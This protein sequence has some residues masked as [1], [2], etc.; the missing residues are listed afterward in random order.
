VDHPH[1]YPDKD[2][3][4][5]FNS[6][7]TSTA[8]LQFVIDLKNNR[9][10]RN[11]SRESFHSDERKY[12]PEV[13]HTLFDGKKFQIFY[14]RQENETAGAEVT[15]YSTELELRGDKPTYLIRGK[16]YPIFYWLGI[17]P[18]LNFDSTTG[19]IQFPLERATIKR[20]VL[21]SAEGSMYELEITG[22]SESKNVERYALGTDFQVIRYD[23][24][25]D[26]QT[27]YSLDIQYGQIDAIDC[28]IQWREQS[29]ELIDEHLKLVSDVNTK[30]TSLEL[31]VADSFSFS[32][33]PEP[34]MN[35]LDLTTGERYRVPE[36]G[37]PVRTIKEIYDADIAVR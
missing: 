35:V 6:D 26:G 7:H 10:R 21:S 36:P 18:L 5:F 13:L 15:A 19:N 32:V 25:H 14:P 12:I 4:E 17:L 28:P 9:Y 22:G 16:D 29:F 20:S 2:G 23:H 11:E 1:S 8:Q 30:L 37:K 24:L 31:N 33:T 34:G 27:I 3:V